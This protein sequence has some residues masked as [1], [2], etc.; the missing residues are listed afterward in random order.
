MLGAFHKFL[1]K[2]CDPNSSTVIEDHTIVDAI[3]KLS[4]NPAPSIRES[5]HKNVFQ[6]PVELMA[7]VFATICHA[8]S[9][10]F[11]GDKS[12]HKKTTPLT[13]A[14]VC[15]Q[16]RDIV[17]CTPHI[18][19]HVSLCLD[20]KRYETQVELLTEWLGRSGACPLTINLVF[21]DENLWTE[22]IPTELI[23][24]LASNAPRWRSINFVLPEAW[25][26]L[27]EKTR[28]NYHLLTTVSTQPL[29][30][31]C[32][33]S[34]SKRKRLELFAFAP[35]LHD[36]HLNGYYL[37]DVTLP[38]HQLTRFTLQHV[39][40]DECFDALPKT[41]NLTWCR[42]YTILVND[43][44]RLVVERPVELLHLEKLIIYS[45]TWSDTVTLLSNMS[46]PC[47]RSFEISSPQTGPLLEELPELLILANGRNI[48]R[49]SLT[50]YRNDKEDQCYIDLLRKMP[51]LEEVELDFLPDSKQMNTQF[52]VDLLQ[53]YPLPQ[54]LPSGDQIVSEDFILP[55]LQRFTFVGPVKTT[56]RLDSDEVA[57]NHGADFPKE[58]LRVLGQRRRRSEG[59]KLLGIFEMK[60]ENDLSELRPSEF[61]S[62]VMQGL[63]SLVTEGLSLSINVG[64]TS[65]L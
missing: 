3:R 14:S 58:L 42:I 65:W 60:V 15:G 55:L 44:D 57:D 62:E 54:T 41:P 45:A 28:E 21:V 30:A 23:E 4:I 39:Y 10:K 53:A 31:D 52:I 37:S 63:Q 1:L 24:I 11:L 61:T 25:Y 8:D 26:P 38:W 35:S 2:M 33:L 29:W 64:G 56:D 13:L 20:D 48:T 32:G 22:R 47:L 19:S 46:F 6:L 7:E 16:W 12:R 9:D 18:W 43:V 40:L 49:L 59:G 34:P 36:L 27:L 50:E 5:N 51:L 17:W